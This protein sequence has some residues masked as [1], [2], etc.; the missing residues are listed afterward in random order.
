MSALQPKVVLF[1]SS[2]LMKL[3]WLKIEK[4]NLYITNFNSTSRYTLICLISKA[5]MGK[6]VMTKEAISLKLQ[7]NEQVD[8]E[9]KLWEILQKWNLPK[10]AFVILVKRGKWNASSERKFISP[11]LF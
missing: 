4:K 1:L 7:V 10:M 5:I 9:E 11:S 8:D 6:L 3:S 2:E